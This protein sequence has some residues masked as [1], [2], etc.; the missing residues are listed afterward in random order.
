M[1]ARFLLRSVLAAAG[2]GALL[3]VPVLWLQRSRAQE[4]QRES[5][6]IE[7]SLFVARKKWWPRS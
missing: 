7:R 6:R 2:S 5:R 3:A 4:A 1:K